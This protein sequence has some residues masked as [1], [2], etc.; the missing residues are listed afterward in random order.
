MVNDTIVTN[1]SVQMDY[2]SLSMEKKMEIYQDAIEL[3]EEK[4]WGHIKVARTLGINKGLPQGWFYHGSKPNGK[5]TQKKT[6]RVEL[7][8]EQCGDKFRVPPYREETARF[9]SKECLEKWKSENWQGKNS[10]HYQGKKEER[11]CKVCGKEFTIPEAWLRK[12]NT[13]GEFC[14]RECKDEWFSGENSPNWEGGTSFLP[15]PPEWEEKRK[16]ALERDGYKC[17]KCGKTQKE[18]MEEHGRSL[19]VHHIDGNKMNSSLRNLITLCLSC[20]T[21]IENQLRCR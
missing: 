2:E 10:P 21:E 11:T 3:R 19:F 16:E 17:Q 6:Q 1:G 8:C 13:T 18:H 9:C 14:S 20:H 7:V 12:D 4:E 15:Y 5:K